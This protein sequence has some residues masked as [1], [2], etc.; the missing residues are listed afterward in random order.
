MLV[1]GE[2]RPKAQQKR[3]AVRDWRTWSA[4]IRPGLTGVSPPKHPPVRLRNNREG[5]GRFG[6]QTRV[7]ARTTEW[8]AAAVRVADQQGRLHRTIREPSGI[9]QAR[10]QQAVQPRAS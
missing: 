3:G 9:R 8:L 4:S 5:G 10:F 1:S 6:L 7:G 2:S